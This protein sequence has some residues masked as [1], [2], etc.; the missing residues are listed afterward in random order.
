[1]APRARVL[2]KCILNIQPAGSVRA[3]LPTEL[4]HLFSSKAFAQATVT[5]CDPT[6]T[7]RG[8]KC[9]S[10]FG[11]E[12]Q[13]LSQ[14]TQN[15]IKQR[16]DSYYS[17]SHRNTNRQTDRQTLSTQGQASQDGYLSQRCL[18]A[19]DYMKCQDADGQAH[20]ISKC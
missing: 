3:G 9:R 6:Q 20:A 18:C 7:C 12:A 8:N 11:T 4:Q 15:N 16:F 1:V 17:F 5:G 10:N 13:C 2:W 14:Q 19:F